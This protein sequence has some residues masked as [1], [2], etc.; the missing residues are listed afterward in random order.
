MEKRVLPLAAINSQAAVVVYSE[1]RRLLLSEHETRAQALKS[2]SAHVEQE[3]M[4]DA[5]LYE[6]EKGWSCILR[7]PAWH[8]K[9]LEEATER[10]LKEH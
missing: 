8:A 4:T 6:R 1:G 7:C 10:L 9:W 3:P 5:A 2:L